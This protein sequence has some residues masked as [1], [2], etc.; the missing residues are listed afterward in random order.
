MLVSLCCLGGE[1]IGAAAA[2]YPIGSMADVDPPLHGPAHLL[3]GGG[4]DVDEAFRRWIDEVR[5]CS[6]CDARLDVVVLRASGA[7]G[8]N[9]YLAAFEGV[10][11][12]DTFV[13]RSRRDAEQPALA[14]LVRR[15][16]LV[17]FA[18]GDQCRYVRFFRGTP[19]EAAV[20]AVFARG[21][22][23]GGSSAGLAIQ[24]D[25][26]YDACGG[27]ATSARALADPFDGRNTFT[28]ELFE[29]PGFEGLIT[30]THFSARDRM[31]RTLAFLA[32]QL[33]DV[34]ALRDSAAASVHALGV[35]EA[36][37][38]LVGRTGEAAVLG[39]GAAYL[40]LADHPPEVCERG[41]PLTFSDYKI[42]RFERGESF[43]LSDRPSTGFYLRSVTRGELSADPYRDAG[44]PG[45]R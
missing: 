24:G 35:D 28:R 25:I 13:V 9:D 6:S 19:L 11:S 29:W 23:I 33:R 16:E 22:G 21:G 18:G 44:Q 15:A 1:P 20:E 34:P 12:V 27:S 37:A 3:A 17:F 32:R 30:D 45:G 7:D 39:A 43:D 38:V 42:W 5:G 40:V 8:Y 41:E 4:G 14:A 26:V 36:T 2:R 31:G 10:D